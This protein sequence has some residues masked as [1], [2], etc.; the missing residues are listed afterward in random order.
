MHNILYNIADGSFCQLLLM[1]CPMQLCT[2][3]LFHN[4]ELIAYLIIQFV[5]IN[6]RTA[7]NCKIIIIIIKKM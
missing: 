4:A 2:N 7:N 3:E 6:Y 5:K 1:L